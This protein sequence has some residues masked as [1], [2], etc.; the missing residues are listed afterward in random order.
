MCATCGLVDPKPYLVVR[1]AKFS[2]DEGNRINV[3]M[4]EEVAGKVFQ[5]D[6]ISMRRMEK[7]CMIAK[8]TQRKA[9]LEVFASAVGEK[10]ELL[11]EAKK[12]RLDG[13]DEFVSVTAYE[14]C[15]C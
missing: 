15:L 6:G 7:S 9:I 3:T 5:S 14:A 2:D 12:L 1:R 4:F 11:V 10:Y 8:D 13:D